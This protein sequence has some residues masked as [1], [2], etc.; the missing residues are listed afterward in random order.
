MLRYPM[1]RKHP[2]DK[3]DDARAAYELCLLLGATPPQAIAE[4]AKARGLSSSTVRRLISPP[5]PTP[6]L[7]TT[8][9]AA[10]RLGV[11]E[12]QIRKLE[13]DG[14]LP[15]V[16]IGRAVRYRPSDLEG[17]LARQRPLA[18]GPY[19]LLGRPSKRKR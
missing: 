9:Q 8:K 6:E 15:A 18:S 17:Y 10:C 1:P 19:R 5:A 7:L 2:P 11:S 16:R 13:K 14:A 12:S 4:V 3:L